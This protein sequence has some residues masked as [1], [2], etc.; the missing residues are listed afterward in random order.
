MVGVCCVERFP[1]AADIARNF[2]APDT[3]IC[4]V[5]VASEPQKCS[6]DLSRV[7]KPT[8]WGCLGGKCYVSL[9]MQRYFVNRKKLVPNNQL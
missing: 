1:H 8:G 3:R 7:E 2:H 6:P 4:F 9:R 5:W